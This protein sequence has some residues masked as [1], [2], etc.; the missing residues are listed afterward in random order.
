MAFLRERNPNLDPRFKDIAHWYK[1]HGEA[2]RVRWDYAFFQMVHETNHLM[3]QRSPGVPGDVKPRQNNFAGIGTTGG[4]VPGDSFPDVA[5][6]VLAQIQHLV[7]YSGERIDKPVAPRTRLKQDDILSASLALKRSVRWTDL[8]NRWAADRSYWRAIEAIAERYR[9]A[10]CTGREAA[11]PAPVAGSAAQAQAA[12]GQPAARVVRPGQPIATER[13]ALGGPPPVPT[14]IEPK[15]AQSPTVQDA[16]ET[17]RLFTASYGGRK[18][19]LI[20]AP[21]ADATDYHV[22]TVLDGFERSMAESF[23]RARAPGGT[24]IG[25][26]GSREEAVAKVKEIC[27]AAS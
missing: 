11:D 22:V 23:L 5:T 15:A 20:R 7:V 9:G 25:E 6:G 10:F 21:S 3:F 1:A 4:G 2:W 26:F 17:C 13:A 14:S 27:P 12:A 18:T 16:P 8:V 24:M 19:L